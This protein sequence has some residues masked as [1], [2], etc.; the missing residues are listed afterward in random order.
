MRDTQ[1][2]AH[3]A[4]VAERDRV[5]HFKQTHID[6]LLQRLALYKRWR[7]SSRSEQLNPAQASLLG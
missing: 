4:E 1:I 7:Y 3:D 5:L 2:A 6:Q